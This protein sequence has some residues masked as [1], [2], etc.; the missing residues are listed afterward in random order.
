MEIQT[1]IESI[2]PI[3]YDS[4]YYGWVQQ[5]AELLRSGQFD[6]LDLENLLEEV[7]SLGRSEKRALASQ[8]TRLYLHLLKWQF[9]PD[10][11][12]NSWVFSIRSARREI[13]QLLTDN[14][15]LKPWLLSA[16]EQVYPQ[17]RE[18][19][20][21]ETKLPLKTFPI[22]PPFTWELALTMSIEYA[23]QDTD[24]DQKLS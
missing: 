16:I 19:A 9:Q 12:S 11:R 8:I 3:T 22:E 18:Q 20:F 13:Q 7:E 21:V 15:S 24:Q 23:D 4:D 5:Q 1:T 17:A 6:Q 2:A 10:R 14:P